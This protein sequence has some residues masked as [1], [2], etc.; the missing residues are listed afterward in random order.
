MTRKVKMPD[1]ASLNYRSCIGLLDTRVELDKK[2]KPGDSNY[3]AALSIMAAKLSYENELVISS[4]VQNHWHMEFLGFYNCWNENPS[5]YFRF[6]YCNDIV[7]RVPYDDST[8]LFKHFGTC[9]YFDSFYRG[10]VTAEEPNKN[11]FSVLAVAPKLVNAWWELARSFL[12][13]Y[14]EGPEYTEGWLMRLARVA[15]LVMP[16]LPPHAPQDYVNATR[17]GAASLGPLE[18]AEQPL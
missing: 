11:Y 4:V 8:L 9:L 1:R 14:A 16:G 17:L 2:I 3:H 12:I 18:L 15:A 13:G 7:P 6:V 5:R 10:Q